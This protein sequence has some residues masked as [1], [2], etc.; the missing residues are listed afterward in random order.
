MKTITKDEVHAFVKK[1]C[2]GG[3]I[4][5]DARDVDSLFDDKHEIAYFAFTE[6]MAFTSDEPRFKQ[7]VAPEAE[8]LYAHLK[9]AKS[10]LL[11]IISTDVEEATLTMEDMEGVNDIMSHCM[12]E[13]VE[14]RWGLSF[15]EDSSCEL[16][17]HIFTSNT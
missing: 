16:Q 14:A 3:I 4:A 11:F 10:V 8:T 2:V 5:L 12:N 9:D 7:L 6:T 13:D 15:T 1:N 17:L